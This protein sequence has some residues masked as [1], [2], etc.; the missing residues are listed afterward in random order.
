MDL[1]ID[2]KCQDVTTLKK[3][4]HFL[5]IHSQTK[6]FEEIKDYINEAL[7]QSGNHRLSCCMDD[8]SFNVYLDNT[9]YIMVIDV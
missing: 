2:D 6:T 9:I 1:L 4:A 3:L 5:P 8:G 7:F